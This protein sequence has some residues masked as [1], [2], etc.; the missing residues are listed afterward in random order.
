MD[1]AFTIGE[2]V[3]GFREALPE[4]DVYVY[5]NAS[6]DL[7]AEI[8]SSNGAIVRFEP[9]KGKGRVL[10][11]MFADI[12]SDVYV[13]AD[14]DGTYDPSESPLLV[15]KL[16]EERLDMVIG[17]RTLISGRTGHKNGNRAFNIIYK[18]LFG[19]GFTDIFSGYRV[20]SR[21]YVK[22]FPTRSTGF[23][24][25]TEMS[26]HSSQLSLP[27]AEL[28]ISYGERQT[29]SV[30]KLRTIPDGW[31]ILRKMLVLLKDNRPMA[32]FGFLG[33]LLSSVSMLL[34]IP[35]ILDFI[36]TGLVERL[37]TAIAATGIAISALLIFAL[38]VILDSVA[39]YRIEQKRL[40]Y[41]NA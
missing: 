17:S 26:V 21:R 28:P 22:S 41:L 37:P 16:L 18:W 14:G 8:A 33:A 9:L 13:I 6:T 29:G 20:L 39:R 40:A 30:S 2:V 36:D 34:G 32:F 4:A 3:N 5:D 31:R 1:E 11:R 27:V 35:V 15:K 7:T 24:I 10:R 23:E 25:E 38:G 19:E 12:D